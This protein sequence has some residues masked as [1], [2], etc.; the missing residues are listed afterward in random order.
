VRLTC[1]AFYADARLKAVEGRWL[2]SADTPVGPSMGMT[3]MIVRLT[4]LTV[5]SPLSGYPNWVLRAE[6]SSVALKQADDCIRS[7]GALG[8]G[9]LMQP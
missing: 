2:A 7:A 5:T 9:A 4:L 3:A 6:Q 8:C 1:A